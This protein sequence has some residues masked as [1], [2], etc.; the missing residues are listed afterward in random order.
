LNP[1]DEHKARG[2]RLEPFADGYE[3]VGLP[4]RL[5][6]VPF[7]SGTFFD[8]ENLDG[9][10]WVAC[11]SSAEPERRYQVPPEIGFI[12]RRNFGS[13]DSASPSELAEF[14]RVAECIRQRL[15]AGDGVLV[16]CDQGI[17]RTGTV[18][19]T[20]L[21]LQGIALG[22]A[23][24]AIATIVNSQQPGWI[25]APR[26]AAELSTL[27]TRCAGAQSVNLSFSNPENRSE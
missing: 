20:V 21:A 22:R 26:F 25:D 13:P 8:E 27:I 24:S 18:I 7:P 17:S 15:Q 14:A 2:V 23:A 5:I 12:E 11:L 9:I 1:L 19:G 10:R 3:V 6:G 4:A 16:H